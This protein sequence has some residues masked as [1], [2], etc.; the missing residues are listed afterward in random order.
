[1]GMNTCSM[2][3]QP[4][5]R[6]PA[7]ATA[8]LLLLL[9]PAF[10]AAAAAADFAG[11]LVLL[12]PAAAGVVAAAVPVVGLLGEAPCDGGGCSTEVMPWAMACKH[13]RKK[14]RAQG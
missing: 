14:A 7:P 4:A 10:G 3:D 5:S 13:E 8:L 2:S 6:R 9:I 11:M 12:P 1:M